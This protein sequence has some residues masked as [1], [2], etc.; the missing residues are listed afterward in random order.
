M[1]KFYLYV[2]GISML[3]WIYSF[4]AFVTKILNIWIKDIY[5]CF[6]IALPI[7]IFYIHCLIQGFEL[8]S[9]F[10]K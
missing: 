9:H 5:F 2:S 8:D 10:K 1:Q 4:F 6:L 7:G 3:F